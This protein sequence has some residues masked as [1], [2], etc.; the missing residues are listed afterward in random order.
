MSDV[1]G[2]DLRGPWVPLDDRSVG[3]LSGALGVFQIAD[4]AGDVL[5][6]GYAGGR[7]LFGLR[8]TLRSALD[9]SDGRPLVFRVEVNMQY[10]SRWKELLM[11]HRA[12][13]GSLPILNN[14]D[15]AHGLGHMGPR[16]KGGDQ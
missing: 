15:D 4:P 12:Q 6:V 1:S 14:P 5:Q 13:H 16:T 3:A 2:R 9:R 8:G 11:V 10:M 7:S